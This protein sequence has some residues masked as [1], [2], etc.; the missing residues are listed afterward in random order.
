MSEV[1]NKQVSELINSLTEAQQYSNVINELR[2]KEKLAVG[3]AI[4]KYIEMPLVRD[5]LNQES[6][7]YFDNWLQWYE[8]KTQQTDKLRR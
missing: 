6:T 7:E 4:S 1:K 2:E 8:K 5:Y 3:Y